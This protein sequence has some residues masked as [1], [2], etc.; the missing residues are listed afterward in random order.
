MNELAPANADSQDALA[1]RPCRSRASRHCQCDQ[2][3]INKAFTISLDGPSRMVKRPTGSDG[4]PS[5]PNCGASAGVK[6]RQPNSKSLACMR[7]PSHIRLCEPYVYHLPVSLFI[8]IMHEKIVANTTYQSD[9]LFSLGHLE[10]SP[11]VSIFNTHQIILSYSCLLP[12][13][14]QTLGLLLVSSNVEHQ[15]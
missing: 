14:S 9:S 10:P 6:A 8:K 1:V 15:N 12:F 13:G 4:E 2:Q 3:Q 5:S 7:V 11:P